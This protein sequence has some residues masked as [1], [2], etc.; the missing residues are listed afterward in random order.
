[1]NTR[2]LIF[3]T[4]ALS[5][6]FFL[7]VSCQ[8]PQ[9]DY[10]I[11]DMDNP[12]GS[13]DLKISDLLDNITFVPLETRDDLLLTTARTSF[14]VTN[15]Y[16]L[17]NTN[18]KVLQFDHKGKFIRV[19]AI[20]GNG[21]NEYST[22]MSKV[23]DEKRELFYYTDSRNGESVLCIDLKSGTILEPIRPDFS[24]FFLQE[25]D[26]EG[27]LYFTPSMAIRLGLQSEE[28][29]D[30]LLV[31]RYNAADKN[32]TNIYGH[33]LSKSGNR[34]QAVF[35]QNNHIFFYAFPYSDT[36][37]VIEGNR[38]NPQYILKLK[39]VMT[40]DFAKGGVSIS[41]P[42][43]SATGTMIRK[44]DSKVTV[45]QEGGTISS[46]TVMP[47]SLDYLFLSKKGE[48][49]NIRSITIDPIALTIDIDDYQK[50]LAERR[51]GEIRVV[52]ASLPSDLFDPIPAVSG[53]WCHYD[54]EASTMIDL[55]DQALKSNQLSA[56]QRKALEELALKI[57]EESNPVLMIGKAK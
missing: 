29:P 43:S 57:D 5:A 49:K 26:S 28:T 15:N 44:R 37:F 52:P 47:A 25:T 1:M 11:I 18:E 21:P 24:S 41:F 38:N 32:F 16:I 4:I 42:L 33:H 55:I 17:V 7:F 14:T 19:L 36:L 22:I 10:P 56:N 45:T 40:D 46:I 35:R 48:L 54:I 39:N 2:P 3:G 23:V 20:K 27:N 13:I 30:S 34:G 6:A 51:S 31:T 12:S 9:T 53:L 50:R 8:Q